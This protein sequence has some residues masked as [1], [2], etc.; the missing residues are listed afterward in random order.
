MASLFGII[1]VCAMDHSHTYCF[2]F[3]F[4]LKVLYASM[5]GHLGF[6]FHPVAP[7]ILSGHISARVMTPYTVKS[8]WLC[9]VLP[10]AQ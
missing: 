8:I 1:S 9:C 6:S 3:F 5:L 4:S 10:W 2:F 7:T